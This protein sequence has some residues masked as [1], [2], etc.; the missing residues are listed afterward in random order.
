MAKKQ[1]KSEC[2]QAFQPIEL[3]LIIIRKLKT[4]LPFFYISIKSTKFF[5][6]NLTLY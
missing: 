6:L 3:N 5:L 4:K 1:K 2:K